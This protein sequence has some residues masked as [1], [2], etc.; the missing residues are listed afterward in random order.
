[1]L[2]KV[3][4]ALKAKFGDDVRFVGPARKDDMRKPPS[5][6]WDPP[7]ARIFPTNRIG[8]GPRDDGDVARRQW[9]V[10]VEVWGQDLEATV[11]LVDR[12][13][14]AAHDLGTHFTFPPE[15]DEDWNTGGVNAKGV[16]CTITFLVNT[17]VLRTIR[18]TRPVTPKLTL[19]LNN[20]EI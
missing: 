19:K 3:F 8:G 14:A 18:P 13:R 1:M 20:T 5:I 6:R 11:V 7:R 15:G 4:A 12:L 10:E 2:T 9:T 17:P 16:L